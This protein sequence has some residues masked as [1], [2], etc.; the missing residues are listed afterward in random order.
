MPVTPGDQISL[1]LD[2]AAS[3]LYKD[4]CYNFEGEGK[5]QQEKK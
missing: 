1:A 2:V 3:E 4:G 5:I